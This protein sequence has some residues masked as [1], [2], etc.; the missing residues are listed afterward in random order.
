ME[1]GIKKLSIVVISYKETAKE[2]LTTL[3][4]IDSQLG[5]DW[6]N[7]EVILVNDAGIPVAESTFDVLVNYKPKYIKMEIN[8]G[9][10]KAREAG[11]EASTSEYVMFFDTQDLFPYMINVHLIQSAINEPEK[12]YD[13]L[14]F[15][16]IREEKPN[17][18]VEK[19]VYLYEGGHL[20]NFHGKV[21][22]KH[23]IIDAGI[24][25]LD[26][27]TTDSEDEFFTRQVFD[28]AQNSISVSDPTYLYKYCENSITHNGN[29]K[30][31]YSR[32]YPN[33]LKIMS[34]YLEI[35]ETDTPN[36]IEDRVDYFFLK[37]YLFLESE[38]FA[39]FPEHAKEAKKVFKEFYQRWSKYEGRNIRKRF[40]MLNDLAVEMYLM[41]N[42]ISYE[43]FIKE[44]GIAN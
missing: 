3:T 35:V 22:N 41:P 39:K 20:C 17:P 44:F 27:H 9:P 7:L 15:A 6:E 34:K 25:W 37:S 23:F 10:L 28:K 4:N 43:E 8:G 32:I 29:P 13:M 12:I 30:E 31:F 16:R 26:F 11:F 18:E 2:V 19:Y 24:K 38:Y 5:V 40:K 21:F 33:Y 36:L 42:N 1:K 14:Y